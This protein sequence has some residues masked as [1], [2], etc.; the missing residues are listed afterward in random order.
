MTNRGAKWED[1]AG[2]VLAGGQSRRMGRPKA[3]LPVGAAGDTLLASR[4]R[5]LEQVVS[6]VWISLPHGAAPGA[7]RL[8]D[9][10]ESPGPLAGIVAGLEQLAR[11]G[12]EWLI[13]LAVDMPNVPVEL[14]AALY[15]R[16]VGGG[17]ALAQ[18]PATGRWEPLVS[19]WHRGAA[20]PAAACFAEGQRA[21]RA[22]L[23][24]LPTQVVRLAEHQAGW[25]ANLNT[26]LEWEAWRRGSP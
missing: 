16:R 9:Q 17:V 4:V 21:V 11:V 3:E 18:H 2:L 14:L 10:D 7:G 12:A 8:V 5:L 22:V 1:A 24:A 19:C 20:E 6:P 26:P 23:Q 13:V 25:L 15:G